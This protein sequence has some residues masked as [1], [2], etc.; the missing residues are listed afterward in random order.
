MLEE[1]I[2]FATLTYFIGALI[3][4]RIIKRGMV[5]ERKELK[6]DTRLVSED[7]R[8]AWIAAA[9]WLPICLFLFFIIALIISGYPVYRGYIRLV[10]KGDK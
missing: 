9:M 1:L 2:I 7:L 8:R 4:Y 6:L 3:T 5:E 10:E